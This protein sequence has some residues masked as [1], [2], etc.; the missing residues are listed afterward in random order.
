MSEE[1]AC[2]D[3]KHAGQNRE[4]LPQTQSRK[5][6]ACLNDDDNKDGRM[7]ESKERGRMMSVDFRGAGG[8]FTQVFGHREKE[9]GQPAG[10]D[11][12]KAK[13]SAANPAGR[14]PAREGDRKQAFAAPETKPGP[15]VAPVPNWIKLIFLD[16]FRY[17]QKIKS[18]LREFI[19]NLYTFLM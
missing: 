14:R 6:P 18:T 8:H 9:L 12:G 11:A 3:E 5:K 16:Q 15:P 17:Y 2:D 10:R 1:Q 4:L 19:Q 7:R 13:Q